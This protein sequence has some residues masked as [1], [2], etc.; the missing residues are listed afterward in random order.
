M[1]MRTIFSTVLLII[2]AL[3][4]KAQ[5][6][7]IRDLFSADPTARVFNNKVYL[8]PSHDIFPPEGQRQ[9]WFCMEDYHVFS[10]E[11]LTDWTDHGVIVSQEK[12][13]WGKPDG[14]SMWAPDCVEKDGKYYFYFPN[15][16]KNGQ[17]FAVGVA[18]SDSPE[19]PFTLEPEPIKGVMG[20]DPC[21]LLDDDGQQ[22]IYWAG[23]PMRGAR[24]KNNMK[25]LDGPVTMMEG[26][27]EGFKEGPFAFKRN[28]RYYLTFPWVRQE[29]GTETL[30]YAISNSPLGPWD[31]RGIIMAEHANRC[32][33]NHHSLV[34]YK[35]Q[36]YLFYHTNFF[37][38]K[39]DK[40]RSVCI[41]KLTFNTDG[42]IQEVKETMRGVGINQATERIDIDRYSSSKDASFA[43]VDTTN[44][45]LGACVTLSAGGSWV[46]YDGV[47]FSNIAD[48]Y[49]VINLMAHE[50]TR[51]CVREKSA[52]GKVIAKVDVTVKSENGAFRRD[53][54]GQWL[55]LT[56]PLDY[57]PKGITDLVVT[58]EGEAVS[59]DWLRFKNRPKYFTEV[60]KK[61]ASSQPDNQGFIRRWRLMEPLAVDVRSNIIFTNSWLR[62]KF[63]EELARLPKQKAKWY[64]LDSENYNVKLFRFAEK[65]GKQT[66]GS[67]FWCETIIEC[68]EDIENVRL[69]CG[70]NGASMWWLN[71]EEVLLLE[72]DRRMVV[73][74]GMSQR[75]SLKKGRNVLRAA[76]INGPGL[77]DMCARFLDEKGTPITNFTLVN[78]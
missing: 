67:F 15:G 32:W 5:N 56:A 62:D 52:K 17:G 66:Y 57:T 33:T 40:R 2:W 10:S 55:T 36:W 14:Y 22:Y 3:A 4:T 16:P 58:C 50:N 8:Y 34:E 35:G 61:D 73:D 48:G 26:L 20:I 12:V 9:D 25:A 78:D 37:S 31:F 45:L 27:P 23:G 71:G 74:D 64:T 28:G 7:V 68:P 19:G 21:V 54:S 49:L 1:F 76:V 39:D 29:G 70:S 51:L 69:A 18:V 77:S 47:D 59:V 60:G 75:L 30:A 65:Y 46:K 63:A 6:P 72:G 53:M 44:T 43:Y 24:L 41:E 13:P 11:N 42:T 38:P